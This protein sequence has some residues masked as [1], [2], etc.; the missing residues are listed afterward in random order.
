MTETGI[1]KRDLWS[2]TPWGASRRT[3]LYIGF[4][5]FAIIAFALYMRLPGIDWMIGYGHHPEQSFNIDD[6]RFII[7]A[8]SFEDPAKK[9]EGYTLFMTAQLYIIGKF[10]SYLLHSHINYAIL[11]R[12]ISMVYAVGTMFLCFIFCHLRGFSLYVSILAT[13]LLTASP[14]HIVQ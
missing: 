8:R 10:S 4:I 5:L 9:P 14:A 3:T 2:T 1:I 11:I 12:C 7:S 13:F 6:N